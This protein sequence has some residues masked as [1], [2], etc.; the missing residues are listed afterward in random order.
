MMGTEDVAFEGKSPEAAVPLAPPL[1]PAT[2]EAANP[3]L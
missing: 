2:P 1:P 3:V